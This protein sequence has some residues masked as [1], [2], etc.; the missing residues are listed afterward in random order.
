M[1][2]PKL[3]LT[4]ILL[5]NRSVECEEMAIKRLSCNL[6][7]YGIMSSLVFLVVS[8][9]PLTRNC[10]FHRS[11]ALRLSVD[12]ELLQVQPLAQVETN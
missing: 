12:D 5:G 2:M 11:K 10:K 8:S 4:L 3:S 9:D 7:Q 6:V 1:Q